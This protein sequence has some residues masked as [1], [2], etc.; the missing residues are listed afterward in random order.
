VLLVEAGKDVTE[1][2]GASRRAR[3]LPGPRYFNPDFTWPRLTCCSAARARTIRQSRNRARYE[4][5]RIL[6]GGRASTG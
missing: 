5:A 1:E 3:E 6:G 4:Q 2:T